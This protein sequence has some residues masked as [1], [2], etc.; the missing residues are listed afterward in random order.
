M[1]LILETMEGQGYLGDVRGLYNCIYTDDSQ[2]AC[3]A[4]E[5]GQKV[6]SLSGLKELEEIELTHIEK[7]KEDK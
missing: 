2:R 7:Y 5:R 6:Y 4:L 1:Y 3:R